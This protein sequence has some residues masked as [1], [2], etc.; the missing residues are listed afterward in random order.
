LRRSQFIWAMLLA[1]CLSVLAETELI[2][3]D[4]S[5][6]SGTRVERDGDIYVLTLEDGGAVVVPQALVEGV[7][8]SGRGEPRPPRDPGDLPERAPRTVGGSPVAD[9]PSGI[10]VAPPQTLAGRPDR[11]PTRSEQLEVFGSPSRFQG[12]VVDNEWEPSSD[13]DMDP[14][15]KN[16]FAPSTWAEGPIDP[17]WEP[18]S[19]WDEQEDVLA[20]SRSNWQKSIIDSTWTPTDGFNR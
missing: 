3:K 9:G 2:M 13:W 10:R 18:E 12:D 8:L 16:N 7:R 15:E 4:G 1:A 6:L 19:A 11:P 17:T 20:P 14:Q 5:V